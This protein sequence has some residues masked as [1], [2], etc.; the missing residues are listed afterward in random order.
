MGRCHMDLCWRAELLWLEGLGFFLAGGCMA[1]SS[2]QELELLPGPA[3]CSTMADTM[4]WMECLE[5]VV[6]AATLP[7]GLWFLVV[8]YVLSLAPL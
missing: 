3:F 1:T 2:E 5:G 6:L 7:L 4:A 8:E